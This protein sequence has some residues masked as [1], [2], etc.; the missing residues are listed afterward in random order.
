MV[1]VFISHS[2]DDKNKATEFRVTRLIVH[3]H[4]HSA[5]VNSMTL[6]QTAIAAYEQSAL[7]ENDLKEQEGTIREVARYLVRFGIDPQSVN[8]N[9]FEID[10]VHFYAS[11]HQEGRG[12]S[13]EYEVVASRR[14]ASCRDFITKI[15]S[16]RWVNPDDADDEPAVG[17]TLEEFGQWLLKPHLCEFE[18]S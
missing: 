7:N 17:L 5:T 15:V 8:S 13:I 10:E 3:K 14:C 11:S 12:G 16:Q 9:P 4:T 2:S 6:R 1:N 18:P